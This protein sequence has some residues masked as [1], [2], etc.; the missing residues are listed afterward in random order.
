MYG[1]DDNPSAAHL[2]R[3]RESNGNPAVIA[4]E[5]EEIKK[6]PRKLI[7]LMERAVNELF[8]YGKVDYGKAGARWFAFLVSY[9]FKT[10]VSDENFRKGIMKD[11]AGSFGP[12]KKVEMFQYEILMALR[13]MVLDCTAKFETKMFYGMVAKELVYATKDTKH[14]LRI[15]AWFSRLIGSMIQP[16]TYTDNHRVAYILLNDVDSSFI[17]KRV[18]RLL[19]KKCNSPEP[20]ISEGAKNALVD[21]VANNPEEEKKGRVYAAIET[22][23]KKEFEIKMAIVI[24]IMN[25]MNKFKIR[26]G[27]LTSGRK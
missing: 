10:E 1:Y 9:A 2:L 8:D 22:E 23:L 11:V 20:G 17:S 14:S 13:T 16:N 21:L 24:A 19:A 25:K 3:I 15:K 5:W 27:Y 7:L 26:G 18:L 6:G 12:E 4:E